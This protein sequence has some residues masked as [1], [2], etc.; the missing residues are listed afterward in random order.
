[1]TLLTFC[2]PI[3]LNLSEVQYPSRLYKK[4]KIIVLYVVTFRLVSCKADGKIKYPEL[5]N[6]VHKFSFD[7]FQ[8][9][10]A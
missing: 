2:V 5:N 3:L 6:S 1:M 4:D 9:V 8:S 7:F 10:S